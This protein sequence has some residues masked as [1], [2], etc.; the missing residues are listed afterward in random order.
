MR[1]NVQVQQAG[2]LGAGAWSI[3]DSK[4]INHSLT[5]PGQLSH[6]ASQSQLD[7]KLTVSSL[8]DFT[9]QV[10]KHNYTMHVTGLV[11]SIMKAETPS[12]LGIAGLCMDMMTVL[13]TH[14][15]LLV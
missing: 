3:P 12:N 4:R 7:F 9:V 5:K 15:P 13:M 2:H 1:R 10:S 14:A 11:M 6:P 8:Q